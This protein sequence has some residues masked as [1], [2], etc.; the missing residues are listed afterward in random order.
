[1][2]REGLWRERT[3]TA[4]PCCL[5]AAIVAAKWGLR[6]ARIGW[7]E[8]LPEPDPPKRSTRAHSAA[9]WR[10]S[11]CVARISS[12]G[13]RTLSSGAWSV[14]QRSMPTSAGP[15]PR[16]PWPCSAPSRVLTS[17]CGAGHASVLWVVVSVP[18]YISPCFTRAGV[19]QRVSPVAVDS[20]RGNLHETRRQRTPG[21]LLQSPVMRRR[22]EKPT[23]ALHARGGGRRLTA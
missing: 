1:V 21:F 14:R 5:T 22:R 12:S 15:R 11:A 2:R 23:P 10:M 13:A 8:V 19:S 3:L 17:V 6:Q 7:C 9:T 20:G 16:A 18:S 4:P